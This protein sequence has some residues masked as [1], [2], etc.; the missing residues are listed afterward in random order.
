MSL[1]QLMNKRL[2][3]Q[4]EICTYLQ[5][6]LYRIKILADNMAEC[7]TDIKGQGYTSF[8]SARSEFI[9]L[10]DRLHDELTDVCACK[11]AK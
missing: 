2:I 5:D 6:S 10:V 9:D 1:Y 4:Q 8:V 3:T 11:I 7:A